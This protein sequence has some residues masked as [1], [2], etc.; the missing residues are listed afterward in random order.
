MRTKGS[1]AGTATKTVN[2]EQPQSWHGLYAMTPIALLVMIL[3]CGVA[4]WVFTNLQI[5]GTEN[6]IYGLLQLSTSY[7]ASATAS[8]V[9]A[10][11][12]G[13]LNR[14]QT[15]ADAIGWGVQIVLWTVTLSPDAAL[16]LVHLKH[17]DTPQH[18]LARNAAMLGKMRLG[19]MWLL[20]GADVFTDFFYVVQNHTLF[21]MDG[22]HPS[23]AGATAAGT[24]LAGLMYPAVIIF[25]N[26]FVAKYL[27]AFI[28]ALFTKLHDAVAA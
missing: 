15:I 11:L 20:I 1:A 8:Q 4:L 25:I 6:S 21:V 2:A 5:T 17:N 26:V 12:N 10:L 3:I 28:E 24:I 22:W 7:P 23:I 27:F 14:Y 9:Q 16:V 18:H 19:L 13:D